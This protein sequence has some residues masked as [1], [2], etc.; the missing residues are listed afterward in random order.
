MNKVLESSFIVIMSH[1]LNNLLFEFNWKGNCRSLLV[2]CVINWLICDLWNGSLFEWNWGSR[3][4][5]CR[6]RFLRI[7][8]SICMGVFCRLDCFRLY[9]RL[10]RYYFHLL[11]SKFHPIKLFL[12][13]FQ[14]HFIGFI[15]RFLSW[16][17][18]I[19]LARLTYVVYLVHF[20]Y[21][22]A[23]HGYIRKPY[24]YT[25]FTH[26]EHYFGVLL[27]VFFMAFA[28]SLTVE[29]PLLNLEKLLI[30]PTKTSTI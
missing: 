6:S 21:L 15:N 3:D 13:L 17:A 19:P 7:A 14:P 9:P 22:T 4:E 10:W 1:I 5:R 23:Y 2:L 30:S 24:Y 25:K 29:V 27:M 8:S 12:F 20:T 26:A 18:F 11:S 16:K 28:I